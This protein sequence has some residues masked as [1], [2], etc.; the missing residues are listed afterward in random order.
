[1]A[2]S[3]I[4]ALQAALSLPPEHL[5]EVRHYGISRTPIPAHLGG[6]LSMNEAGQLAL[7]LGRFLNSEKVF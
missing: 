4:H 7:R 6:L 5:G 2:A 3:D 1:M